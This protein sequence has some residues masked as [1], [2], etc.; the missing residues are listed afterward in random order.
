MTPRAALSLL[1]CACAAAPA[2]GAAGQDWPEYLGGPDRSHYSSLDQINTSNVSSLKIAWEYHSG[3]FGQM[4][5][6]PIVVHGTLYGAT[7]T[8]QI[9]ALDAATG[10]QLW[11]FTTP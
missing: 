7:G 11:R 9:L 3:D 4:Q 2:P 1:T 10:K 8:S 5:C 6:N